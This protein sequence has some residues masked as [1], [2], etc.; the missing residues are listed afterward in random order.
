M[1]DRN[2]ITLKQNDKVVFVAGVGT[3]ATIE[4]GTV[5]KI[6]PDKQACTVYTEDNRCCR[7]VYPK[8]I[9]KLD[10]IKMGGRDENK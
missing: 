9:L 4:V 10:S 2:G 6:Y 5:K 8:R 3:G 7:M 1:V